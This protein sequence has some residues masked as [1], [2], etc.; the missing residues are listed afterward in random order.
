MHVENYG[1][2]DFWGPKVL[3]LVGWPIGPPL[4]LVRR[5]GGCGGVGRERVSYN[6]KSF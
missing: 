1:A 4:V 2:L 6:K 3:V 5:E